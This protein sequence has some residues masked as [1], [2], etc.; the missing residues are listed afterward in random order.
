MY[1]TY[2]GFNMGDPVVGSNKKLRQ[3]LAYAVD[4]DTWVKFFND[5]HLPAKGLI[6]PNVPGYDAD[7]LPVYPFDVERARRLMAEAGYADGVDPK[8]GKRLVLT[9]EL[10]NAS[11]PQQRQSA[12]LMASFFEKLGVDLRLSFNNWPEFLKKLER[13]QAQMW[14]IGWIIP[15]PDAINFLLLFYSKN[16]SPGPNDTNYNNPAYDKLYEQARVMDDS[17][18]RTELYKRMAAMVVNDAPAIFL[19][20]PLSY[21]LVQPWLKNYKHHDCPYPNAKYY[22]V[23]PALMKH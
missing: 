7:S 4:H 19:T 3:A 11:D 20:H 13:R 14:Q 9:M 23:D 22:R 17:P 2:I 18:E 15:Y 10:P 1:D 5:R 12:D 16:A 8:S 6:P 21:E